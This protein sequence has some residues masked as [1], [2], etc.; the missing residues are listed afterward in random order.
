MTSLDPAA[1]G[2]QDGGEGLCVR[3]VRVSGN[4][5]KDNYSVKDQLEDTEAL[6]RTEATPTAACSSRRSARRS[7]SA[8]GPA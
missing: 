7:R 5:Q 4:A 1:G 3:Y 8:S 2:A 6:A